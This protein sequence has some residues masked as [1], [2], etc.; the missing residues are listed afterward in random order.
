M[1][2]RVVK[3]LGEDIRHEMKHMCSLKDASVLRDRTPKALQNFEWDQVV[4]ELRKKAST[5]EAV[6]RECVQRTRKAGADQHVRRIRDDNIAAV[7]AA[8][9]LRHRCVGMNIVQRL[10]SLNSSHASKQV[11][12]VLP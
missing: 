7:C 5:L 8:I 3:I 6:L 1:K 10:D 11:F 4:L 2:E 12:Y 9:L